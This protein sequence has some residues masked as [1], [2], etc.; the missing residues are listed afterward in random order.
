MAMITA[1]FRFYEEL[2]DFLPI[3]KRKMEFEQSITPSSSIK[4]AIESLGVPH[5]EVDLILVNGVSVDF[6]YRIK[7]QDRVSVYPVFESID[8]SPVTH[9]RPQPLRI[10]R[11]V[12]DVHL[13][14]LAR[15]LRLFGFDTLYETDYADEEVIRIAQQ[16][17]RIILTRDLGILKNKK[18]THGYWLREINP[19]KQL[20]EIVSR[21]DLMKQC[22]PFIRCLECNG[23]IVSLDNNHPL[24]QENVPIRVKEIQHQFYQ[25]ENCARIY[26]QGTH[27]QKL[28]RFVESVLK[29]QFG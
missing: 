25:C 10:T 22:N 4:D 27:Y 2:N 7:A 26:W 16:E 1:F 23:K 24:I 21:F 12:L 14:K 28:M 19:K 29:D 18:V 3:E 9:L 13:G 6:S 20:R 15:Y 8:I 17:K 5:T 11:F